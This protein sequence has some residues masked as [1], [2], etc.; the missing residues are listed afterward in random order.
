[1]ELLGRFSK[2]LC[3]DT[4]GYW[5]HMPTMP[6]KGHCGL[7]MTPIMDDDA[8]GTFKMMVRAH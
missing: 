3:Y 1:M 8:L 4:M 7:S 2:S 6:T 5:Y